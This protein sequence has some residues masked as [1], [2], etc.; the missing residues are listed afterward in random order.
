[1]NYLT[2][3]TVLVGGPYQEKVLVTIITINNLQI[4]SFSTLETYM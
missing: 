1:M 3:I 2:D 4:N